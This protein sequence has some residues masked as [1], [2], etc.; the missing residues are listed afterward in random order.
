MQP[1]VAFCV[2]LMY[3]SDNKW[4][5]ACVTRLKLGRNIMQDKEKTDWFEAIAP[6]IVAGVFFAWLA[7]CF[8]DIQIWNARF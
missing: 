8:P 6:W 5:Y 2:L 4:C 7:W 1:Y 3:Y